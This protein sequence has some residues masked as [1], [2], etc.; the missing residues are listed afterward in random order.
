VL[1]VYDRL[2]LEALPRRYAVEAGKR[3]GD[4]WEAAADGRYDLYVMGPN[5]F[6]RHYSGEV[7]ASQAGPTVTARY[8]RKGPALTLRRV[9]GGRRVPVQVHSRVYAPQVSQDMGGEFR[10][11]AAATQGWYDVIVEGR[12]FTQRYAGRIET[13]AHGISDP[14]MGQSA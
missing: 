9:A 4:L 12:G 5:G 6:V 7:A 11:D 10:W 2:Q 13:G 14:A 1:H 8:E 3:I